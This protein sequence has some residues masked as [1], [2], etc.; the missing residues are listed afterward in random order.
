M[1]EAKPASRA[2]LV[3]GALVVCV[4]AVGALMLVSSRTNEPQASA[5][6][7]A[8]FYTLTIDDRSAL[9][10]ETEDS[11]STRR[12]EGVLS[13]RA[14]LHVVREGARATLRVVAVDALEWTVDGAE[15][16]DGAVRWRGARARVDARD[17]GTVRELHVAESTAPEVASMLHALALAMQTPTPGRRELALP[18]GVALVDVRSLEGND[19]SREVRYAVDGADVRPRD[20]DASP[21]SGRIRSA[22]FVDSVGLRSARY[23]ESLTIGARITTR[24]IALSPLREPP[25]LASVASNE[26]DAWVDV[27]RVVSA[28]RLRALEG[29]AAGLTF[30]QLLADLQ[31]AR[32]GGLVPQHERWLWRATGLLELEPER[33]AELARACT[34]GTLDGAARV[35]A[36]DLLANVAHSEAQAALR[37]VLAHAQVAASADYPS[38]LQRVVLVRAPEPEL[39]TFYEERAAS[40]EGAPRRSAASALGALVGHARDHDPEAGAA[41]VASLVRALDD[42]HESADRRALIQALGNARA[43]EAEARVDALT[44]D[45]DAEVRATA[46]RAMGRLGSDDGRARLVERAIDDPSAAVRAEALHALARLGPRAT[47][48]ERLAD[49]VHTLRVDDDDL[50]ALVAFA[51]AIG[52]RPNAPSSLETLVDALS[53][54]SDLPLSAAHDLAALRASFAG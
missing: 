36:L 2:R 49:A 12:V 15:V 44:R 28:A 31:S 41:Q 42:A 8:R 9:D 23:E 32:E 1:T 45:E 19:G 11:A 48:L 27:S 7:S 34:D 6:T 13:L 52:A 3:G 4:L 17:D 25:T 35:L 10:L 22:I 37:E 47:D 54:R 43:S 26:D 21:P 53:A 33:A 29:R 38:L 18:S 5:R 40:L 46:V 51:R 50:G 24:T 30:A 20:V 16:P 14:I 39:L